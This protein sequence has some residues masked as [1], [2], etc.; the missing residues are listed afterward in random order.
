MPEKKERRRW[1]ISPYSVILHIPKVN[2]IV[3]L[4]P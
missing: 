1:G 3:D 2:I 4:I